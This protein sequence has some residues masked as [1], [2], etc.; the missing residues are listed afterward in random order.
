[1]I[2]EI[3]Y[4]MVQLSIGAIQGACYEL[5]KSY[6][7]EEIFD[8][9]ALRSNENYDSKENYIS[10]RLK[11]FEIYEL[12]DRIHWNGKEYRILEKELCFDTDIME[13]TYL[14]GFIKGHCMKEHSNDR[15]TG[16]SFSGTVIGRAEGK[17]K[18]HLDMDQIQKPENAY[19]YDYSPVT[20]NVMYSM[21]ELGARVL[22][23]IMGEEESNALVSCC[24]RKES[25]VLP[26]PEV[27]MMWTGLET[28]VAA[29]AYLS[30][31]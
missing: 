6:E 31:G 9:D 24:I 17:L 27:K 7:Y 18:V 15:L 26:L 5:T 23:N 12:G 20:A 28:Y 21:P 22:L 16:A 1:M 25:T 10:Y 30:M 3:T 29:P 8:F 14:L 4:P 11:S 2:P 13:G 19:W